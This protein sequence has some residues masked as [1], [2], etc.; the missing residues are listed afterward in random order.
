MFKNL[1]IFFGIIGSILILPIIPILLK[2]PINYIWDSVS[3]QVGILTPTII[4]GS[5]FFKVKNYSIHFLT[6]NIFCEYNN[7]KMNKFINLNLSV[8]FSIKFS[9]LHCIRYSFV[10]RKV[11]EN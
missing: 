3:F 5:I 8:L 6:Q 9:Q 2:T 4:F 1:Y 11:L 7:I 10:I